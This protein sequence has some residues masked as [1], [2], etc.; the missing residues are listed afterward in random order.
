MC[1][2]WSHRASVPLLETV[3]LPPRDCTGKGVNFDLADQKSGRA[4]T[5]PGQ[6]R[7]IYVLDIARMSFSDLSP[8]PLSLLLLSVPRT[9]CP[10]RPPSLR[11]IFP[12]Q[13]KHSNVFL[14]PSSTCIHATS[15]S[16]RF[17]CVARTVASMLA[18]H[19]LTARPRPACLA[20]GPTAIHRRC[21]VHMPVVTV[22]AGDSEA[23]PTGLTAAEVCA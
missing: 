17:G 15:I 14:Q 5:A 4:T 19:Q 6:M 21:L 8:L 22:R 18:H 20:T 23:L 10:V 13:C 3:G 11:P 16:L 12:F 9:A 2:G 1:L 7:L